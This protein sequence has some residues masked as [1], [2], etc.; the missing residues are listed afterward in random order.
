MQSHLEIA[1]TK[2]EARQNV[3]RK[4]WY[5]PGAWSHEREGVLTHADSDLFIVK[6]TMNEQG[7][8]VN[9]H[10]LTLLPLTDNGTRCNYR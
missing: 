5:M 2:E 3:G 9:P 4:V 6:F 1:M 10:D 8:S 7:E